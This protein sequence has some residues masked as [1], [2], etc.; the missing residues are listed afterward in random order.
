M[1][2]CR[3][4]S[5]FV[6]E[7]LGELVLVLGAA[8]F[9]AAL[10]RRAHV[11]SVVAFMSAGIA[12]GPG[13]L[14]LVEDR[15]QIEVLAEIGVVLLLFGV[16]LKIS[17]RELVAL[18][19]YVF[20][21]GT[22]QIV[23]TT[24]LALGAALWI[25]LD[26]GPAVGVAFVV[27]LSSTALVLRLLEER[28]EGDAPF[29]RLML[30]ILIAQDL[31][32]VPIFFVLPLLAGS[33]GGGAQELLLASAQAAVVL[34]GVALGTRLLFP[35]LAER[36]V[37]AG[38][39]EL[40]TLVTAVAVFGTAL[41]AA[42]FGLSMALGAFLAGVVVS[43]SEYSQRIVAEIEPFR[44]AFNSL[45]FVSIGMLVDLRL[46]GSSFAMLAAIAVGIVLL[47]VVALLAVAPFALRGALLALP[48][49]AGLA[50]VGE[51]SFVIAH[52]LSRR[53]ILSPDEY[54]VLLGAAVPTMMLAPFALSGARA[55]MRRRSREGP[56]ETTGG[57]GAEGHAIVVGY[58]VAGRRVAGLLGR[59]GVDAMIVELNLDTARRLKKEGVPVV[60]GDA[61]R[62]AVL[63]GAGLAEARALVVTVPDPAQCR[64][65]VELARRL[66]PS[67]RIV[68]RTRYVLEVEGLLA[69]GADE[70]VTDEYETALE[71]AG[72]VLASFG[73]SESAIERGKA[74]L[75]IDS[76]RSLRGAGEHSIA[77]GALR[78]M[79]V[80]VGAE[81]L[82]V[83]EGSPIAGASLA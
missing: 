62:R 68:V 15:H 14:G 73:T 32:I 17:L 23:L 83:P 21:A 37:R 69:L 4:R 35:W 70:V 12:I 1:I 66:A 31:A 43:G 48:V 3:R 25:G 40:F 80:H 38:S 7:V 64:A 46:W 19:L 61:T 6:H 77:S 20:G 76:A 63:E 5:T 28:G 9:A 24:L 30:G 42:E 45:F 71:L 56:L 57:G 58:G 33:D 52:E 10:L 27:A 74:E 54:G 67:L 13:G 41:A 60:W 34:V 47:K 18:K 8:L 79:L 36:A 55:L 2:A 22:A 81:E 26:T 82:L 59:L 72:R 53:R 39:R 51:F 78:A 50:H 44:D 16:G 65:T 11:P 49:V 29:G 75:R